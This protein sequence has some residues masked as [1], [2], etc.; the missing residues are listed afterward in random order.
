M[1]TGTRGKRAFRIAGRILI[2]LGAAAL[3]FL[4]GF[5]LWIK[6]TIERATFY[7]CEQIADRA[8][9]RAI[10][11]HM[12][13]AREYS[14]SLVSFVYDENGKICALQ[15]DSIGINRLKAMIT[16]FIN[17]ELSAAE[18]ETVAVSL[19]TL[20]G[21]S[22]LY[23]RGDDLT[24]SVKPIGAA[25]TRLRSTFEG[26]GINQTIHSVVLEVSTVISPLIPGLTESI[27]VT[28]EFVLAQTVLVGEV[29]DTFSNIIL[30][31]QHFSEL[32]EFN[33]TG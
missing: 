15:A 6:P 9:S 26:A 10:C 23:G 28:T 11:A 21:I 4:F 18:A 3:L 8:V 7:Q 12:T 33:L 20:T 25:Q 30:D 5:D 27:A 2:L 13:D 22:Y 17:A 29:P 14:A 24:F 1:R 32:A 31:D 19:G 16:E